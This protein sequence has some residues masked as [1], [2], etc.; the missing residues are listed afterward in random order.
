MND[1]FYDAELREA[2]RGKFNSGKLKDVG[3]SLLYFEKLEAGYPVVGSKIEW[4]KL[5]GSIERFASNDALEM[6]EFLEFFDE[7]VEGMRLSGDVIY[8]GDGLTDSALSGDIECFREVLPLLLETPQ[9][10]YLVAEDF[11]WCMCF[12]MEGGM[13]FGR[14]SQ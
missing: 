9:H 13:A 4:S 12:T 5:S 3:D 11:S 14:R 7:V 8:M 1:N 10:H 2:L 6:R